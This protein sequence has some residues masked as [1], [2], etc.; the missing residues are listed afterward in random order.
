MELKKLLESL[1]PNERKILPYIEEKNISGI[2]KKSNLDKTAVLRALEYLGNKKILNLTTQKKKFVEIGVNG[3]LY[4]KKGLPERKL[5]NLL[6]EKRIIQLKEAKEKSSLSDNEFKA[7]IGA[8]KKKAM[9]ELKKGKIIL[10]V[11]KEEVSKKTLEEIFIDSL[12][13]EY[14]S[15][16]SQQRYALKSLQNRKDIIEIT[17]EKT[18]NIEVTS[19]G[20]KIINSKLKKENLIEQITPEL[21]KKESNWKGKNLGDMM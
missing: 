7:S 21:L 4:K 12:P 17:Q 5:L 16:S 2:C 11:N 10:N 8:L 15:L 18:I 1:S 14:D 13:L 19:L 9:I 3:A 20:K 6:N